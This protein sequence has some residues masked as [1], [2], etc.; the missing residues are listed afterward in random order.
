MP[1]FALRLVLLVFAPLT[2]VAQARRAPVTPA[3]VAGPLQQP[4][5]FKGL[6]LRLVGPFDGG[7]ASRAA[8]VPGDP[9]TYYMAT[10]SGGVWK[11]TDGGIGWASIFDDQSVASIGSLAVAPS[12]PNVIYVGSGEANVR[13]NTTPGNGIYK[14]ADAG[15]TWTHVWTQEGQIGTMAVHPR[16]ADI[17]YAAV[18]GRAFASN[19]ERGIY[20]TRDG[21]KTWQQVLT[22]GEI[23][24]AHV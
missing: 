4:P 1:R 3:A 5:A 20:R 17:A 9:T 12:D 22:K 7:R 21:G 16:N 14:S 15:K 13:G 11:S 23:G 2:V 24:R 8:G 18:L 6:K 10:A 19:P